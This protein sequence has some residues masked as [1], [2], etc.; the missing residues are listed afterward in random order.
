MNNIIHV[1]ICNCSNCILNGA[2]DITEAIES[3]KKLKVQYRLKA[4]V[5]IE[6]KNLGSHPCNAP[7]VMVNDTVIESARTETVMSRVLSILNGGN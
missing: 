7:V 4:T 2:E 1:T 3:L 5:H 6:N